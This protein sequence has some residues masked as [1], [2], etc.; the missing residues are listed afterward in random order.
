MTEHLADNQKAISEAF[1]AFSDLV[2]HPFYLDS[3]ELIE[4]SMMRID[5]LTDDKKAMEYTLRPLLT[6]SALSKDEDILQQVL[7]KM[8]LYDQV[9]SSSKLDDCI[10]ALLEGS[11]VILIDSVSSAVIVAAQGGEKRAITEPTAQ[12]VI[13][14]SKEGFVENTRSNTALVR[15]RLRTADLKLESFTAGDISQT[16]VEIM[17]LKSKASDETVGTIRQRLNSADLQIVLESGYIEKVLQDKQKTLFPTI[18]FTERPDEVVGSLQ[19][20]RIAVFTEGTPFVLL[21]PTCFHHFFYSTEDQ[22]LPGVIGKSLRG[23]RMIA[24]MLSMFA[25]SLYIAIMTHHQGLIPTSLLISLYAQREGVPFP[26]LVEALIMEVTFEILREAGVRMPRA[27][28]QA[29]SI[30]GA[31]VIGQTAVQAGLVSTAVVIVVSITAISSFTTPNYSLAVTARYYRFAF[32]FAAYFLG[33][34]SLILGALVL[35]SHLHGLTTIKTPYIFINRKL[36]GG[37]KG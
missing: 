28:G 9:K 13:R 27:I 2:E 24:F 21:C 19:A 34:Y 22:Y 18:N 14:G 3:D 16:A 37:K 36:L 6:G 11:V 4:A 30:V 1:Q 29:V 25:P 5:G 35:L 20:G 10:K 7:K 33:F 31:L 8:L 15:R 32:M 17:Y 12:M 23:L 26:A